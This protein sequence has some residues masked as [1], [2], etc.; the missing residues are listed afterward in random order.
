VFE[1]YSPADYEALLQAARKHDPNAVV[2]EYRHHGV[3]RGLIACAPSGFKGFGVYD[4]G[5]DVNRMKWCTEHYDINWYLSSV[6][7][8]LYRGQVDLAQLPEPNWTWP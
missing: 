5:N 8:W 6:R 1:V 2:F 3:S 4:Q 7:P